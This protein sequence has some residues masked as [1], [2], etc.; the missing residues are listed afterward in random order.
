MRKRLGK[1]PVPRCV[2]PYIP[3]EGRNGKAP[4]EVLLLA[5]TLG[6]TLVSHPLRFCPH[7]LHW[8]AQK[9]QNINVG[10]DGEE[11][12]GEGNVLNNGTSANN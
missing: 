11:G 10:L 9:L 1:C 12:T 3:S 5:I 7:L 8:N 4:K 6:S 2:H